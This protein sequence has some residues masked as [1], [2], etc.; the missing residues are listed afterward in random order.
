LF[1]YCDDECDDVC[2]LCL[3]TFCDFLGVFDAFFVPIYKC[4]LVSIAVPHLPS[5]PLPQFFYVQSP[6]PS[7]PRVST[8]VLVMTCKTLFPLVIMMPNLQTQLWWIESDLM[9]LLNLLNPLGQ[10]LPVS[11]NSDWEGHGSDFKS[12]LDS[13]SGPQYGVS[14]PTG[15]FLKGASSD[16]SNL[17]PPS[18]TLL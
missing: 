5:N 4:V 16:H 15:N 8:M 12:I 13:K 14:Q 3:C 7:Q 1:V 6:N 18:V 10:P 9:I 11:L 2:P 17:T